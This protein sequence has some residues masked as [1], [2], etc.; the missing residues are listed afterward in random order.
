MVDLHL[1]TSNKTM[2][3]QMRLLHE[4][5]RPAFP[6]SEHWI[7]KWLESHRKTFVN[8]EADNLNNYYAEDTTTSVSY[9]YDISNL[10][11]LHFPD[12]ELWIC[13]NMT[14]LFGI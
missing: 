10:F 2:D 9:L 6:N 8:G 11:S 3:F 1:S 7:L 12:S 13:L 5:E 4:S 14:F